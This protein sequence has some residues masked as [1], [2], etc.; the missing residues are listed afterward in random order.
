VGY[1]VLRPQQE[2]VVVDLIADFPNAFEKRPVPEV[3]SFVDAT[4][5]GETKRA[6]ATKDSSRIAWRVT[7][8]ENAWISLSAGLTEDAWTIEG[9]GVLFR[10][11][12]HDDELLNVVINP[13]ADPSARKWQDFM[14]D[15]SEYAGETVGIYL[16]TNA[17]PPVP[18]GQNNKN[19]D[20]AVWGNPRIV[21]R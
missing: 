10:V 21:T 5:A 4:I 16:K 1:F 9:D 6:I 13:Y 12:V 8:P 3:F 11:S 17:S 14:L 15:L 2:N 7:V 18:P 20:F 19:G